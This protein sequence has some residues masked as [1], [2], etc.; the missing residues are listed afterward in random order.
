MVKIRFSQLLVVAALALAVAGAAE[1]QLARPRVADPNAPKVL[2]V[3]FWYEGRDSAL[4]LLVADGVRERLRT[5]HMA[6][7]NPMSRQNINENLVQSG[8][9]V[10]VPLEASVI[11]QLARFLNARLI[12]EGRLYRHGD[13]VY[14]AARLYEAAGQLPQSANVIVGATRLGVRSATG[15]QVAD[16]LEAA[17][18]SFEDVTQCRVALEANN[19]RQAQTEAAQALRDDPNSTGAYLCLAGILER[20]NAGEDT[21]IAV[22][23][24]AYGKD[25]LN[26]IVMRR[27]A[28]KYETHGDTNSLVDMLRRILTIDRRDNELRIGAAQLLVRLNRAAD[29]ESVINQ[30]LETNPASLELL[31]AKSIAQASQAQWANA[32]A[33]L[34]QV[35]EIDSASIDSTFLYRITN[36]FR[37]V[38]DSVSWLRWARVA[39]QRLPQAA[40][41]WF[42]AANLAMAQADTT[43]SI[44]AARAYSQLQPNDARGHLL[45]A[46]PMLA[47][48]M[49][50]S[51]LVHAEAAA[52]DSAMRPFA[53]LLFLQAGA[54]AY[55]DS[56]W[57]TAIERLSRAKE[58][59]PRTAT[60]QFATAAFVLGLSQMR[61]GIVA[62]TE[63]NNGSCDAAFRARQL[64]GDAEANVIAGVAY[65]RELANQL[66]SQMFPAY[67]QRAEQFITRLRCPAPPASPAPGR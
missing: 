47:R 30:G 67:K 25:T 63:A 26:T 61:L 19:L 40:N 23:R 44:E 36:Y 4:A 48:G 62:D 66:L 18:R 45:L 24:T 38:P 5:A 21:V 46:R 41:Y 15:A 2:T 58:W 60:Q 39:N 49:V 20:Q 42:D 14:I 50:D 9:P 34:Q 10:D 13:S 51:A 33:T 32:G 29:A 6:R 27:L 3:P 64:F 31:R 53:G 12:I 17:S 28:S 37:Q 54:T 55:R 1:A 43:T 8:F 7:Y 56:V 35:G 59:I 57:P 11:R 22:L 16:R 65:N 52:T